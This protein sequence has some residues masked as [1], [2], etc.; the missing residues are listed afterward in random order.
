MTIVSIRSLPSGM[1]IIHYID[2]HNA[3]SCTIRVGD[4]EYPITVQ[5]YK[6][7]LPLTVNLSRRIQVVR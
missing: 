4:M 3:H 7:L 2:G 5:E 1:A 6:A